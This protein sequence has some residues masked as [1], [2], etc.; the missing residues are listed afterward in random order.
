MIDPFVLL[1]PLLMLG[2][3]ALIRF[4]GCNQFFGIQETQ[5]YSPPVTNIHATGGDSRVDLTWDYEPGTATKFDI[6]FH[7]D[8][9]GDFVQYQGAVIDIRMTQGQV[10][11][12]STSLTNNLVNAHKY[13][14]KV[15]AHTPDG[16]NSSLQ[17]TVQDCATP[18]V[19]AFLKLESFP[20]PPIGRRNNLSAWAGMAVQMHADAVA[21]QLGRLFVET[22]V[23]THELRIIDPAQD[24]AMIGQVI[25]TPGG[26]I[27]DFKYEPLSPPTPLK[28]D[29][30]YYFVSREETSGDKFLDIGSFTVSAMPIGTIFSAVYSED[31]APG[32]PGPYVL[33][34]SQNQAYGPVNFTY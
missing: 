28:A 1:T 31:I 16:S 18:G 7:E 17:E 23:A 22:N 20:P 27:G 26:S 13:C 5:Q 10:Q 2:V 33:Y 9:V 4:V 29:H 34:G 12:G 15:V 3:L 30:L 8:M 6:Y 32:V 11:H 24:D 25:W 14:F 19:T 21:T